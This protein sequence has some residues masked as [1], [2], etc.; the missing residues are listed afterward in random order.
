M[1][2]IA[3]VDDEQKERDLLKLSVERYFSA[4]Q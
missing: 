1:V 2:R 4:R 3:I